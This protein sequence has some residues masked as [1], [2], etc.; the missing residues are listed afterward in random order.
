MLYV[1]FHGRRDDHFNHDVEAR[2]SDKENL[3]RRSFL[4]IYT[5]WEIEKRRHQN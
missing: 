5:I 4:F 2:E 3:L 1:R